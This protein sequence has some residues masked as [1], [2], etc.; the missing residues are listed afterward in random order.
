MLLTIPAMHLQ[1]NEDAINRQAG[2]D[3]KLPLSSRR[4]KI[5]KVHKEIEMTYGFVANPK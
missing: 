5:K 3:R 2:K 4:N 1:K